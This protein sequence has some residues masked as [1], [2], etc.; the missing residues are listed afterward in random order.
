[1]DR[2]SKELVVKE[3]VKIAK[4]LTAAPEKARLKKIMKHLSNALKSLKSADNLN[5]Q[6]LFYD[7]SGGSVDPV[8]DIEDTLGQVQA[9]YNDL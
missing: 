7:K 8:G 3:L 5:M 6:P 9:E 4:S 2:K 1:M